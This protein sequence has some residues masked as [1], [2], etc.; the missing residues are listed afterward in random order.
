[1]HEIMKYAHEFLQSFCLGNQQNQTILHQSLELFLNPGVSYEQGQITCHQFK[2]PLCS[3]FHNLII[4]Y[5]YSEAINDIL[6]QPLHTKFLLS[7]CISIRVLPSIFSHQLNNRCALEASIINQLIIISS[8][9][10]KMLPC[11]TITRAYDVEF[12][13]KCHTILQLFSIVMPYLK[14]ELDLFNENNKKV[15]ERSVFNNCYFNRI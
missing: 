13:S 15:S 4:S 10:I 9:I 6:I 7:A 3:N 14:L 5:H 11:H 8:S 1:M 2:L 12:F